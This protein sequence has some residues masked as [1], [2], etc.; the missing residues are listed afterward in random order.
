MKQFIPHGIQLQVPWDSKPWY[1]HETS[2][3]NPNPSANPCESV[4]R[5]PNFQVFPFEVSLVFSAWMVCFWE[6]QNISFVEEVF[7][8]Q[9]PSEVEHL[10]INW[11][12]MVVERNNGPS[13]FLLGRTAN[14][15]SLRSDKPSFR[16]P[17]F[18]SSSMLELPNPW[19]I[20]WDFYTRW[21]FQVFC[22]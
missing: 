14:F 11:K 3:K 1:T 15:R 6:G 2:G 5:N 10:K 16:E 4:Q 7:G 21:W 19:R 12:Q 8:G 20:H 22:R 9:L 13:G 17:K 18:D